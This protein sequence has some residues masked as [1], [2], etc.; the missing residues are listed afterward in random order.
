MCRN[1]AVATSQP[2]AAAAGLD[3]LR[4][5]GTAADAAVAMAAVL[6]V[7]EPMSTGIGGDAFALVYEAKTGKVHALNA[8]GRTAAA[9]TIEAYR[10]RG[11]SSMPERG[12]MAITVPGAV[13]GWAALVERFGTMKLGELLEPAID[14]A[15][16]GFP[17]APITA[18]DWEAAVPVL[19]SHPNSARVFLPGGRAPRPGEVVRLPELARSLE[20]IAQGGREAFYEGELAEQMVDFIAAEGGLLTREDFRQHQ[21]QWQEPISVDYRGYRLYECPPNGQGIIALMA[22]NIL[23][24]EPVASMGY[25]SPDYWHLAIEALKL[26]F[27]DAWHYV[28]DPELADV[29]VE[30]LLS[31]AYA[32]RRRELISMDRAI[33]QPSHGHPQVSDTVYMTAVD[34]QGNAVSFINSIFYSFGSGMVAGETGIVLQNRGAMF[35][36]DPAHRNHLAPRKLPYHTI[37]PAMVTKD[38][39]LFMSYGVMGGLMQPQGHVQVL[40]NIVDFGMDVQQALDAPRFRYVEGTRV[41]LE[42]G[43]NQLVGKA[44]GA[45]GHAI[46][47]PG[48]DAK[49]YFGFGGGQVI[50]RDAETGVLLAGSDPRK[51]GLAIGF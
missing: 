6:A 4:R 20:A 5:G 46:S 34:G 15:R 16:N 24:Q 33:A 38:G 31:P 13:S 44:L 27:H 35:S 49:E 43:A 25:T 9:A 48:P 19:Q 47:A 50:M 17:V 1:G 37:I 14:Y 40:V 39:Q 30:E 18:M 22:L 21:P 12:I 28:A 26:A 51:D 2:L 11:F 32:A 36:F 23:K 42:P 41:L 8:S 7:V 3:V 10:E 45:R 29:P